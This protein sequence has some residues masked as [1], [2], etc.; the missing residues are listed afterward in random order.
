MS[1]W[2][3]VVG[4]AAGFAMGGPIGALVGAVMGH[5]VD[6][7]NEAGEATALPLDRAHREQ[8]FAIAVIVLGAK[9]AKADGQV[10]RDEI[11]AF[12]RVFTV[13]EHEVGRVAQIFDEAKKDAEGFEP[14]ARQIAAL[15]H[16]RPAVLEELLDALLEIA[17]ADGQV[18]EAERRFLAEVARL[19]GLDRA[20]LD[21]LLAMCGIEPGGDADPYAILGI[22][23]DAPMDEVKAA[24]RRLAREHHPD[25]LVAE[26]LPEEMIQIAT[27]KIAA[28]NEAYD[29]ILRLRGAR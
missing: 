5:A 4:G 6:R 19:F 14:Y 7:Y 13:P 10:T 29:R 18:G 24:Y 25:R 9:M 16:D 28:I 20:V 26:G 1:F 8:A 3:K 23:R 2:G 11:A 12:R 27:R 21:R 17:R 15:F 22:S